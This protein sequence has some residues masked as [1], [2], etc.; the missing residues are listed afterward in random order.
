M[1]STDL[2]GNEGEP[3]HLLELLFHR[4][5]L[6][7]T[8]DHHFKAHILGQ[9]GRFSFLWVCSDTRLSLLYGLA[10]TPDL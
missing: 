2:P 9:V 5:R 7:K 3:L 4:E 6:A 8:V 1:L 10:R